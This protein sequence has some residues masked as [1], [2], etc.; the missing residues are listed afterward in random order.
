M[1]AT[2]ALLRTMGTLDVGLQAF[3]KRDVLE[4]MGTRGQRSIRLKS[5]VFGHQAEM[6]L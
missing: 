1:Q 3:Y 5:N 2:L 6:N 4:P